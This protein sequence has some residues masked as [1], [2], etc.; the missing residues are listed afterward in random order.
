MAKAIRL[1]RHGGPEV[2]TY[3]EDPAGE[4]GPGQVRV[5]QTFIGVN[6]IDTY[7]RS[8]LYRVPLPFTPGSEGAGVVEAV[9]ADVTE[10][11][12]GDRVAYA[13]VAGGYAEVRLLPADRAVPL[14]AAI[15]HRTA[16]P[17]KPQGPPPPEPVPPSPARGPGGR[18]PPSR[19]AGG[20]G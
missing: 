11:R 15:H 10:L 5:R 13:G 17:G 1:H 7:Q 16:A 6:F 2:L 18:G 14:P 9:G 4:P 19:P 8:G 20:R 12:A 3:E